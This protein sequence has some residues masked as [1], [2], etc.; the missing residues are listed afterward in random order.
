[1]VR[2]PRRPGAVRATGLL[3]AALALSALVLEGA[4]AAGTRAAGA[5]DGAQLSVTAVSFAG[6]SLVALS[7]DLQGQSGT[8][9]AA[10]PTAAAIQVSVP[11]GFQIDLTKPTGTKIG[12]LY[13]G[14]ESASDGSGFTFA[15]ASLVV[16]DPAIYAADPVAQACAPGVHGAVWRASFSVIGQVIS[17]P[18]AVD[19]VTAPGA[20]SAYTLR[21]C[22]FRAPSP[23]LPAG[24]TFAF[25]S[26]G[27]SDGVTAPTTPGV[28][29]WTALVTPATQFVA[30]PTAA[31][32]LRAVVPLPQSLSLDAQYDPK[33]HSAVLNGKLIVAGQPKAGAVVSFVAYDQSDHRTELGT[34][35]TDS[36]GAFRV[37]RPFAKT[38]DVA[39]SVDSSTGPCSSPSSA[40]GGC[41]NETVSS[42]GG[43]SA[44]VIVPR[45][46]D[47][48]LVFLPRD[49]SLAR[50]SILAAADLPGDWQ[51][52]AGPSGPCPEFTPNL[53]AFTVGG[54]A[55][56][57]VF[58]SADG[59]AIA[60]STASVY[61]DRKSA[62]TAIGRVA[63]PAAARCQANDISS[64]S[65]ASISVGKL[66][67]PNIGNATRA[68]R[69]TV[70]IPQGVVNVDLVFVRVGRVVVELDVYSLGSAQD[71]LE[72]V[73]ARKIAA[74]ARRQ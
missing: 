67:L 40:P 16:D 59:S 33:T 58:V 27:F 11:V 8:V 30:D 7:I 6:Q 26:A 17:L 69:A 12:D 9:G 5:F 34:A 24:V 43:A 14:I 25:L 48:K 66:S 65:S 19:A 72:T 70:T 71:G 52:I 63:L 61:A 37:R 22:P 56:S 18:I 68:Y 73:L 20:T 28:Y 32:E 49:Q 51:D 55:F 62:T 60:R 46:T 57:R 74:R 50:S 13:A 53:R 39:A 21:F 31:F 29:T 44:T 41:L 54:Q 4:Q 2:Q 1:M 15:D 42:P 38:A 10:P 3:V 36:A 35:S 23:A 64:G 47:A 45:K